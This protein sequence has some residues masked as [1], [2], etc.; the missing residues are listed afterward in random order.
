MS[1]GIG[2]HPER[3]QLI[4]RTGPFRRQL[5]MHYNRMLGSVDDARSLGQ[6]THLR[7]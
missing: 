5:L 4:H 7:L 2:A 3:G 1:P 6:E